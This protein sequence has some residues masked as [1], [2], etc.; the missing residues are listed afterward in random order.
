[1]IPRTPTDQ[2][3][4]EQNCKSTMPQLLNY[5]GRNP[6]PPNNPRHDDSCVNA[7]HFKHGFISWFVS[8]GN[9]PQYHYKASP[10]CCN[11]PAREVGVLL[12]HQPELLRMTQ[13][14]Q[15][16]S[17]MSGKDP[18]SNLGNQ[19]SQVSGGTRSQGTGIHDPF[20][21]YARNPCRTKLKPVKPS[22]WSVFT[23]ESNQKPGL[24]RCE[25][26]LVHPQHHCFRLTNRTSRVAL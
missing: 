9:H 12:G 5:C 2:T 23:G 17:L 20:L 11:L 3:R 7:D 13:T 4:A 16:P 24:L 8:C 10:S 6:T 26:D 19:T 1:M 25:M 21:P 15:P 18:R 14:R 22:R